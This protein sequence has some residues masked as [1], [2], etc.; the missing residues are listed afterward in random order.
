LA[1]VTLVAKNSNRNKA[2]KKQQPKNKNDGAKLS[3]T[4]QKQP[5]FELNRSL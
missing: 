1:I 2:A 3:L 4:S 5:E